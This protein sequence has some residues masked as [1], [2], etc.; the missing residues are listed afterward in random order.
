MIKRDLQPFS[1]KSAI[2]KILINQELSKQVYE[3]ILLVD[4]FF[5]MLRF[6]ASLTLRILTVLNLSQPEVQF[7]NLYD[8]R[9]RIGF[10]SFA[11]IVVRRFAPYFAEKLQ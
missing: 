11:L 1:A 6:S 2:T 3:I 5:S 8:T 7:S 9:W 4:I 10:V